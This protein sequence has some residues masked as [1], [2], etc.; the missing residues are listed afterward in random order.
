MNETILPQPKRKTVADHK[1]A[2]EKLFREMDRSAA[3]MDEDRRDIEQLKAE[4]DTLK[5]ET[6]AI[7]ATMG[8][9]F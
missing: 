9:T 3:K 6:R 8:I 2:L 1:A 4:A 5:A 7:L